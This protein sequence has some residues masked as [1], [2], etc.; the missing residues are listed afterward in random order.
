MRATALSLTV[1][2]VVAA[3]TPAAA[4]PQAVAM[5]PPGSTLTI[6]VVGIPLQASGR[7]IVKGPR[8]YRRVVTDNVRLTGLRS[9]TYRII[10]KPVRTGVGTASVRKRVHKVKVTANKGARFTVAYVVPGTS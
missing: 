8:D 7:V 1:A 2:A 3:A 4:L 9:G 10:A 6:T 5:K